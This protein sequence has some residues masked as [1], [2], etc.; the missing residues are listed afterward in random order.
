[1]AKIS[2]PFLSSIDGKIGDSVVGAKWKGRMY[3]RQFSKPANPKTPKQTSQRALMDAHVKRYQQLIADPDVK[4][5]WNK[6]GLPLVLPG[7]NIFTKYG[8]S[9]SIKLNAANG[10]APFDAVITYNLGIPANKAKLYQL[11]AGVWTDVTPVGGLSSEADSTHQIDDLP[12][13]TYEF[14]IADGDVLKE[15]DASPQAYQA[16]TKWSRDNINGAIVEAKV[17]VA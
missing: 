16:I 3:L 17:I 12:I 6:E 2:S 11:I 5:A 8:A 10:A 15:G 13:G 1:M 9:S 4:S 14:F 7:F